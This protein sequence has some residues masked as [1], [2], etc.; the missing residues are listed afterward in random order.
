MKQIVKKFNNIVKKTIFKVQNKTNDNF[1]N[2]K[3]TIFKVQ[4]KTINNFKI[5]SFNKYLI[6]FISLLFFYIF[7]LLIPLL[8]DKTWVQNNIENKLLNE[9]KMNVST[10]A[11]I[12]YRILPAPHFLIKDSKFLMGHIEKQKL[13]GEIKTLK[14]F[15]NQSNLFDK[16]EMNFKKVFINN[17]NFTLLRSD[18]KLLN[19]SRHVKFSNKKIIINN[20]NIFFK[21]NSEEIISIIKI[22][23]TILFFDDKKLLNLLN[24]NGKVFNVPFIFDFKNRNVSKKYQE[25]N[26]KSKTL[27]LNIFNKSALKKDNIISGENII[28]FF[29]SK[30]NTK[31]D[32]MD[33]LIVFESNNS[34][35]NNL[36][37][38]YNGELSISPFDLD[39]N[40][41][42]DSY[43]ISKLFKVYPI[44]NEFI[45]SGLLFNN[46]ISINTSIVVNSN[47]KNEIF[48]NAK[49]HF[50]IINGKINLNKTKFINDEIGSLEL[51]NSNLFLKN[52]K[53]IFN[54][55]ILINIKNPDRL[56]SFL[57]IN[58]ISRKKIQNILINLDYDFLENQIKF[59]NVKID[60]N[61]IN[62][63]LLT[64]IDGFGDNELN[65]LNKSRKLINEILKNYEG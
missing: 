13:I 15:L 61:N 17:A 27:K 11:D 40:I 28:S 43:K 38:N 34:K 5:S 55:D 59:N 9:F 41:Y 50:H 29:N 6:T 1:K 24:L 14:V 42:L 65:N 26:F 53:L 10:S 54:S 20:S 31:Y 56:F 30:V 64:I 48:Q 63:Q 47:S 16:K 46:N 62:D 7:Y 57:N 45:K 8:Y 36:K 2:Y 35:I 3:K 19:K 44:L 51:N 60:N 22:D 52:N 37:V 33:K 32:V 21:D 23:K 39:L 58:K 49:I 4:N 12:S 18:L 25:I